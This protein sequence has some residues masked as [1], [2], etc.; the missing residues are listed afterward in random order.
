MRK[1]YQCKYRVKTTNP[2][3]APA[4]AIVLQRLHT[5]PARKIFALYSA[6]SYYYIMPPPPAVQLARKRYRTAARGQ[7]PELDHGAASCRTNLDES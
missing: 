4:A 3:A 7:I 5:A 2:I 6:L 1:R